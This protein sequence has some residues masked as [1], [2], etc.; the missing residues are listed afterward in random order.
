MANG[1]EWSD[2]SVEILIEK[3]SLESDSL[4]FTTYRIGQF[5][6]RGPGIPDSFLESFRYWCSKATP[7]LIWGRIDD[8]KHRERLAIQEMGFVAVEL[9]AQPR[10]ALSPGGYEHPEHLKV[11]HATQADH[12][13]LE[14][15]AE[16]SFQHQRHYHDPRIG[17]EQ[18]SKRYRYWLNE[19]LRSPKKSVEVI[20]K[21]SG[22]RV[23]MFVSEPDP[24]GNIRWLLTAVDP[25]K[26]NQGLGKKVWATAI[27]HYQR[28]GFT[29]IS[30]RI[31][32]TNVPVMKLYLQH[33]FQIRD[34]SWGFHFVMAK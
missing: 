14:S 15:I 23:A 8:S 6:V 12:E 25:R 32:V 31:S 9:S 17:A 4:G 26:T 5:E 11:R 33:G 20:E 16:S 18:A 19:A 28:Q 3:D 29:E 2:S 7:K 21:S 30:T 24:S 22:D 1:F 27:S 13:W 34:I 10:L